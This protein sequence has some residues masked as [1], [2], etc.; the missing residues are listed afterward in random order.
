LEIARGLLHRP[1]I[2]FLDEP[3]L[4]LDPQTRSLIWQYILDLRAREG[5]T[6]F[7]TTHYLDE[8][9]YC[10]RIAI[11]DHGSIVALDTPERLKGRVGGDV[12]TL[13]TPDNESAAADIHSRYGVVPERVDGMLRI[14]VPH[15]DE[16]IPGLVQS[17]GGAISSINMSRPTLDDVFLKLTGRAIRDEDAD[18]KDVMRQGMRMCSSRR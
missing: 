10:D 6:L 12:I 18:A 17:L 13:R 5:V 7:L 15:G 4:G 9:E 2:L 1:R 14:E 8:A 3:T 11:I 16:F